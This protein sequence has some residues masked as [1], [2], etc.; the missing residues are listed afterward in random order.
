MTTTAALLG[1][2]RLALDGSR[3][4]PAAPS[5]RDYDGRLPVPRRQPA[6]DRST[7]AAV[8]VDPRAVVAPAS[9]R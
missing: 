3:V 2:L 1:S 5:A 4:G 8:Q 7:A 6:H 9:L